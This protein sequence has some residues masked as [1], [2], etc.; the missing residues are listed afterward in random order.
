MPC[1]HAFT[2]NLSPLH[3]TQ[4]SWGLLSPSSF[5]LSTDHCRA[6]LELKG[7]HERTFLLPHSHLLP[8]QSYSSQASS[9]AQLHQWA[10][11]LTNM[12]NKIKI[13]ASSFYSFSRKFTFRNVQCEVKPR[14]KTISQKN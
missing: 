3:Y 11:I 5:P 2:D 6:S 1:P 12:R 10:P 13:F 4:K 8:D 7:E 9:S 14:R